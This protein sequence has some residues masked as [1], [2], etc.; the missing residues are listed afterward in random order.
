MVPISCSLTQPYVWQHPSFRR[1]VK[2][3]FLATHSAQGTT[4]NIYTTDTVWN[5]MHTTHTQSRT[6]HY[7]SP[8]E[9]KRL[10]TGNANALLH[11]NNATSDEVRQRTTSSRSSRPAEGMTDGHGPG[12]RQCLTAE[13]WATNTTSTNADACIDRN[14]SSTLQTIISISFLIQF[15]LQSVL[16]HSENCLTKCVQWNVEECSVAL[17][18]N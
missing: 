17:L 8:H 18:C 10:A 16:I 3:K 9:H 2:Y 11:A 5:N 7:N 12:R 1:H 4:A 13:K 15:H 6:T 14:L